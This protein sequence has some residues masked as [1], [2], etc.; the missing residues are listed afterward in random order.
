VGGGPGTAP[1]DE[2]SSVRTSTLTAAALAALA[3]AGAGCTGGTKEP[4]R[5]GPDQ[6][7]TGSCHDAAPTVLAVGDLAIRLRGASQVSTV[8]QNTLTSGQRELRRLRSSAELERPVK[9]LVV[10]IGFVRLRVDSRSY[11]PT[12]MEDV[13]A[14]EQRIVRRCVG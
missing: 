10:A 9:D 2:E 7:H 12:L 6:F 3:L 8:D 14:A 13:L 5:P 1:F 4:V 11:Q